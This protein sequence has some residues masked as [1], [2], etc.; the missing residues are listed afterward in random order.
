MTKNPQNIQVSRCEYVKGNIRR[1]MLLR[2]HGTPARSSHNI[3]KIS[4]VHNRR[5]KL[6][7]K[8]DTLD[9]SFSGVM[10][11]MKLLFGRYEGI[12]PVI[13]LMITLLP[14]SLVDPLTC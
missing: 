4:N 2:I 10:L 14:R 13:T 1:V 5:A 12:K 11:N 7:S 8:F 9:L 3:D 6:R